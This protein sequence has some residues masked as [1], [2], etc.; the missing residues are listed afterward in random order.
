MLLQLNGC[1]NSV[2]FLP[3]EFLRNELRLDP[4]FKRA[5]R[6]TLLES[7]QFPAE[8]NEIQSVR[9]ENPYESLPSEVREHEIRPPV[10]GTRYHQHWRRREV[11]ESAAHGYIDEKEAQGRVFRLRAR[12]EVVEFIRKYERRYCDCC[13]LRY[14]RAQQRADR[15]YREP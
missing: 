10:P 5:Q 2:E 15:Q 12:F 8:E 11:C 14:E 7:R 13:R 9:Y 4:V 6:E 3:Y 1:L